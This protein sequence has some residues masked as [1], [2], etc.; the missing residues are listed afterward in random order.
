MTTSGTVSRWGRGFVAASACWLV[1]W[2]ATAVL[3][4]PRRVTVTLGLLG[5]VLHMVFGKAYS[6]VPSYFDRELAVARAPAVHLPLAIVG[7]ACLALGPLTV[8]PP[9][10]GTVGAVLW[11][12]GIALFLVT[13]GWTIRDNLTGSETATGDHNADRRSVDRAANAAMPVAFLYLGAGAYATL[14]PALGLP[15]LVDGYAPRAS[16]LFAAG[17]AALLVFAVGFRL[18]PRF[19]VASPPEPLVYVV[20]PAG[21]LGPA[22]LAAGLPAGLLLQVGALVQTV[23]LVGF[24]A[25][26]GWLFVASDRERLGFYSVLAGSLA[27]LAVVALGLTFAFG[28]TTPD[29]VVVH[30]R[31]AVLGFLGLTIVGVAF[32]FY[33]PTVG[34]F[35]LAG[36]RTGAAV[37]VS[38]AGGLVVEVGGALAGVDLAVVAGR[39]VAL[40]GAVGY[41][42]LLIGLFVQRARK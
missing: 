7:T 40:A 33:P 23:A 37:L 17:T 16:H 8:V 31:L 1:I 34:R 26:Y 36:D 25:A 19:L 15:A 32:Q 29:L 35:P 42:Y 18:L 12:G 10:V 38:L 21:A 14:A 22:L 13:I 4:A 2:Q 6:L 11:A 9:V 3:R 27:G 41:A 39:T 5:F 24:A 20:L 30:Y 28:G